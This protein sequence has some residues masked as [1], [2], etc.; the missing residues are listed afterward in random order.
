MLRHGLVGIFPHGDVAGIT[1]VLLWSEMNQYCVL[2]HTATDIE[3]DP[4]PT[5]VP[6]DIGK[7]VY[8]KSVR[9]AVFLR[10]ALFMRALNRKDT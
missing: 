3:G 1:P 10:S 7:F 5:P 6:A 2:P 8:T 4:P 9:K